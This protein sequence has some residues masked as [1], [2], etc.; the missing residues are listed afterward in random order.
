MDTNRHAE[1]ER[2]MLCRDLHI[3]SFMQQACYSSDSAHLQP[4]NLSQM[5]T[6]MYRARPPYQ[7]QSSVS[8]IH[9]LQQIAANETV[10][11]ANYPKPPL[12]SASAFS[13]PDINWSRVE[14]QKTTIR[15]MQQRVVTPDAVALD[16]RPQ[17]W[18]GICLP[19]PLKEHRQSLPQ[20]PPNQTVPSH[21]SS[22]QDMGGKSSQNPMYLSNPPQKIGGP[23]QHYGVNSES[24]FSRPPVSPSAVNSLDVEIHRLR[25]MIT[26]VEMLREKYKY[27]EGVLHYPNALPCPHPNPPYRGTLPPSPTRSNAITTWYTDQHRRTTD[28]YPST[29]HPFQQDALQSCHPNPGMHEMIPRQQIAPSRQFLKSTEHTQRAAFQDLNQYDGMPKIVD[30]RSLAV[31]EQGQYRNKKES[32]NPQPYNMK[33]SP[34]ARSYMR[35]TTETRNETRSVDSH[36]SGVEC[37]SSPIEMQSKKNK[38]FV[39]GMTKQS[40]QPTDDEIFVR[41][42]HR[43]SMF[44]H[45][46][47]Y[48]PPSIARSGLPGPLTSPPR[49]VKNPRKRSSH[50]ANETQVMA[51][52]SKGIDFIH[53]PRMPGSVFV[54]GQHDKALDLTLKKKNGYWETRTNG[55][56]VKTE[57]DIQPITP[58]LPGKCSCIEHRSDFCPSGTLHHHRQIK[59]TAHSVN[60]SVKP[61]N[62]I[63]TRNPSENDSLI[64]HPQ[65]HLEI[66]NRFISSLRQNAQGILHQKSENGTQPNNL[67]QVSCS[68][69]QDNSRDENTV[70]DGSSKSST[71]T[72]L[73]KK[74][75][76]IESSQQDPH[77]SKPDCNPKSELLSPCTTQNKSSLTCIDALVNQALRLSRSPFTE[78]EERPLV[79]LPLVE[80]NHANPSAT[81]QSVACH[82][83]GKLVINH[84]ETDTC[85]EGAYGVMNGTWPGNLDRER[86][87][88]LCET[89]ATSQNATTGPSDISTESAK[90]KQTDARV[91]VRQLKHFFQSP[92]GMPKSTTGSLT[93]AEQMNSLELTAYCNGKLGEVDGSEVR[94]LDLTKSAPN[95]QIPTEDGYRRLQKV[96]GRLLEIYRVTISPPKEPS[97]NRKLQA[98]QSVYYREMSF[99]CVLRSEVP[100]IPT[101]L[102]VQ[103]LFP[104]VEVATVCRALQ[105]C[106][107]LNRYMTRNEQDALQGDL[108]ER[109]IT[110]CKLVPLDELHDNWDALLMNL[111]MDQSL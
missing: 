1:V 5:R 102:V 55:V 107:I 59:S 77:R 111:N 65:Q 45:Q 48:V 82:S 40:D 106:S 3:G 100:F 62:D 13:D 21:L 7:Y 80:T 104:G 91:L 68:I 20:H 92:T 69:D 74:Q 18:P 8:A 64:R 17:R 53:R 31:G 103:I 12:V 75:A 85:N 50:A 88:P 19:P 73:G 90:T 97:P 79:N 38:R 95:V 9:K 61:A 54:S 6:T 22:F 96:N 105:Q 72:Y 93:E 16:K 29:M 42:E 28:R 11:H 25:G 101:H 70:E 83:P 47:P 32:P 33:V 44:H 99:P 27:Q 41:E 58:T 52:K 37:T 26:R 78:H 4:F 67:A 57:P 76:A 71:I 66:R 84:V 49:L 108:R 81:E 30:V 34:N 94:V 14:V 23:D 10:L 87:T 63:A 109:G 110:S 86:N 60:H 15:E 35:S 46:V 36:D 56:R 24:A 89:Q 2:P 51:K 98:P 43:P 39:Y